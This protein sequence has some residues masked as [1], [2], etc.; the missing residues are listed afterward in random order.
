ML[1]FVAQFYGPDSHGPKLERESLIREEGGGFGGKGA[2]GQSVR[3]QSA[4]DIGGK[5]D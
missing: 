3:L 1:E 5:A 4:K 2:I